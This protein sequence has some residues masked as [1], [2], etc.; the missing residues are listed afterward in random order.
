M[1]GLRDVHLVPIAVGIQRVGL[2]CRRGL[3]GGRERY[4]LI[5]HCVLALIGYGSAVGG[6]PLQLVVR[7][8]RG[9]HLQLDARLHLL[10]VGHVDALAHRLHQQD[11][12]LGLRD[13]HLVPIA[14][15]IQRVGLRRRRGLEG[16]R[17]RHLLVGHRVLAIIGHICAVGGEVLQLVARRGYGYHPELKPRLHLLPIG[18]IDILVH[19]LHQEETI[20]R[21]RDI[22]LVS[23]AIGIQRVGLG[24]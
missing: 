20:R 10:P 24:R 13:V 3:E 5:G 14:I 23:I 8:G 15:G 18:H 6:N 2:R 11:T 16:G 12:M 9:Y 19:G 7:R 22:H 17:E 1:L 4:L 21:L